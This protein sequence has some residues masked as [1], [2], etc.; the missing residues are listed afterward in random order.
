MKTFS[1]LDIY[2]FYNGYF[3]FPNSLTVLVKS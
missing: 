2:K 3:E 1:F